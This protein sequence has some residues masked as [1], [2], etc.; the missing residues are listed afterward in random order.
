MFPGVLISVMILAP[1]APAQTLQ[2]DVFTFVRLKYS[3]GKFAYAFR[4]R[5][6]SESWEVDYPTA[7]E[8][9][10]RALKEMTRAPIN[11]EAATLAIEDPQLFD[12]PFAYIVEAG[13]LQFSPEEAQRLREWCLRGGFLMI[14]D[15]H[16]TAQWA[17]FA[18]EFKKVFPGREPVE[19]TPE[20]PI[21]H[22][23]FDFDHFP[24]VP[25]LAAIYQGT[26]YEYDGRYAHCRGILD[27]NGRVMVLI[28]FNVDLGD[29]WEH[30]ADPRYPEF[31][32]ILGYRLGAN[33]VIYAMTH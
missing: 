16:G 19:L 26:T 21:F 15:F 32:S 1:G 18:Y 12:Y 13:F 28:N 14:D 29:S 8:N 23:Y 10:V 3:S 24:Q 6:R 27:D 7:E 4:M 9:L 22:C 5:F 17:N 11:D 20:H 33:Y 2:N 25:G 31:Y 30:A